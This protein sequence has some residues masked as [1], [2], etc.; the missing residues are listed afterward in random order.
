MRTNGAEELL[1]KR[2]RRTGTFHRAA[3]QD[4]DRLVV[5]MLGGSS[6][7]PEGQHDVRALLPDEAHDLADDLL[8][9]SLPESSV[10]VTAELEALDTED[11]AGFAQL[12]AADVAKLLGR[13]NGD[14]GRLPGIPVGGTVQRTADAL[15]RVTRDGGAGR[16]GLVIRVGKDCGQRP[17]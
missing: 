11:A 8:L 12:R 4:G 1:G 5:P 7:G 16:V 3:R 15:D 9:V 14:V 13:R 6:L 17:S 10:A 2:I